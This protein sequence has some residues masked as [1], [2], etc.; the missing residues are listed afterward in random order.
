[1]KKYLMLL[2][3]MLWSRIGMAQQEMPRKRFL[4]DY[5]KIQFAGNIGLLSAGI[6]YQFFNDAFN[7][8]LIYGYVPKAYAHTQIHTITSK[9]IFP[10]W[11]LHN[12]NLIFSPYLGMTLSFETGNNTFVKLPSQYP[13]GYYSTNAFHLCMLGG[14]SAYHSFNRKGVF[15]GFAFYA[16]VVAVDSFLW[17]KLNSNHIRMSQIFSLSLGI[18]FYF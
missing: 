4:P 15:K 7:T 1:M 10:L 9:N 14:V 17:Y 18:N 8:E 16:E 12:S 5:T 11:S 2:A 13:S 3:L 6:G